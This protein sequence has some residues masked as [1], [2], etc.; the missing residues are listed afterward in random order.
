MLAS[1]EALGQLCDQCWRG[2]GAE[3]R[4]G[5]RDSQGGSISRSW[6]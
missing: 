5:C 1:T 3:A 6:S 2:E 4:K